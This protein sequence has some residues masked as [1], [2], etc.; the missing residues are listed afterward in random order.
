MNAAARHDEDINPVTQLNGALM[1]LD[2]KSPIVADV[3]AA[4]SR[5]VRRARDL[6][7][8]PSLDPLQQQEDTATL[9]LIR[10]TEMVTF[11]HP[12]DKTE[13]QRCRI[14]DPTGFHWAMGQLHDVTRKRHEREAARHAAASANKGPHA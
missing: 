13:D 7:E 11:T 14:L 5:Y 8:R 9:V 6:I 3:R 1:V 12:V 2:S 4:L 10:C